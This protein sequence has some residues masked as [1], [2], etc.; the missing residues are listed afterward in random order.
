MYSKIQHSKPLND[1]SLQGKSVKELDKMYRKEKDHAKKQK[2]K[3]QQK[4]LGERNKQK[5]A[6]KIETSPSISTGTRILLGIGG[7][8]LIVSTVAEDIITCGTGT[9]DD[10][11]TVTSGFGMIVKAFAF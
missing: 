10:P 7:V 5:R 8:A 6:N 3:T 11:V 4:Y 2:I 1:D 9:L